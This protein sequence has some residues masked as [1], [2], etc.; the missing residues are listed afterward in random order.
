MNE[1][2]LQ[3]IWKHKLFNKLELKTQNGQQVQI[4]SVGEQNHNAG[5]DF[6]NGR[7]IID[8]TAWAGSIEIHIK[9]SDWFKHGHEKDRAYNNVILHVV[10]EHDAEVQTENNHPVTTVTLQYD[11]RLTSNYQTLTNSSKWIPCQ[12]YYGQIDPLLRSMWNET[13][14]VRRLQRKSEVVRT[15]MA[16]TNNNLDEVFFKLLCINMGF[17]TNKEPFEQLSRK[18]SLRMIRAIGNQSTKIEALLFGAAGFLQTPTDEYQH[19]LAKEF[20][21]L[22]TKFKVRPLDPVMWKFAR[23]RPVNF[24]TI[25]LAQ[26]AHIV[27]KNTSFTETLKKADTVNEVHQLF[28]ATVS[29]YWL[30]HFTFQKNNKTSSKKLGLSS[31]NNIIINSVFPFLFEIGKYYD[32]A[33]LQKKVFSW[34]ASLPPEKNRIVDNWKTI[35]AEID[36]AYTS[37]AA[38]ELYNEFC[39]QQKCLN[40]RLGGYII[41][42]L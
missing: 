28:Y 36:D 24:P 1:Q 20:N 17:K 38:I 29:E 34:L 22:S 2:F 15:L 27:S 26:L 35:G 39:I 18:I 31:I 12:D 16:Q 11:K 41:R 42:E 10:A 5:P 6:F 14:L 30:T 3:Y 8:G 23:M 25:R 32:D 7:V 13:L 9:S 33:S 4:V 21:H 37:Q 19:T 40:C